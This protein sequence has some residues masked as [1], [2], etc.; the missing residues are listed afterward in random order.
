MNVKIDDASIYKINFST[1]F[2]V[3]DWVINLFN[4]VSKIYFVV[5]GI[6]EKSVLLNFFEKWLNAIY[7]LAWSNVWLVEI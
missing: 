7:V 2:S 1:N 5:I 3:D 6:V 4:R